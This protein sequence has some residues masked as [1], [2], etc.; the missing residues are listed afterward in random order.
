MN[1][2]L[3]YMVLSFWHLNYITAAIPTSKLPLL[4][5]Q[6]RDLTSLIL[7]SLACSHLSPTL[8]EAY[9]PLCRP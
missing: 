4:P 1:V 8:S 3:G 2:A 6:Q 7:T 5:A 9:Y